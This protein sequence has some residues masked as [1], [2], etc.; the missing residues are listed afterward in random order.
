M[1]D[2]RIL[3]VDPGLNRC[4]WGVIRSAGARLEFL[5]CGVITPD[6]R[7]SL[8]Q[9]L[10]GVLQGLQAV[11]Q[12]WRPD[13][14][15][16]EET[17]VNAN[18]RA[19]LTLGQARGAALAALAAAGLPVSEYAPAVIKKAVAGGGRADKAQV[20]F[21]VRRLLPT[22]GPM[23]ADAADALAVALTHAAHAAHL[24]AV[25]GRA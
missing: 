3:G 14:G 17:F 16:V 19:A 25:E 21:M 5:A 4:G 23:G 2:V 7:E 20:A 13:A 6:A 22:A 10:C 11:A 18:P 8:A 9:R 1:Q 24:R 15:A 12:S